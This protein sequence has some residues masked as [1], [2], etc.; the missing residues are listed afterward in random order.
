MSDHLLGT[1]AGGKGEGRQD[2]MGPGSTVWLAAWGHFLGDWP[3][4]DPT[5][6]DDNRLQNDLCVPDCGQLSEKRKNEMLL[7]FL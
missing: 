3:I 6:T 2:H 4:G 7:L 5:V 1:E